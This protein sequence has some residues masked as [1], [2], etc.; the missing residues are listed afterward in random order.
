LHV[1]I[2]TTIRSYIDNAKYVEAN[3]EA[4][5]A[6]TKIL[7]NGYLFRVANCDSTLAVWNML[8]SLEEQ[9]SNDMERESNEDDSDQAC[10]S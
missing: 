7:N 9:S 10:F 6:L 4:M 8:I 3:A 2:A 5:V 1:Y